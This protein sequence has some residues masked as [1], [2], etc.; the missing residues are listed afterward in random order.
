MTKCPWPQCREECVDR[1]HPMLLSANIALANFVHGR[2]AT[3][4]DIH[5]LSVALLELGK[6]MK[7]PPR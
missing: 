5:S 4:A 3:A 6:H 7:D 1:L 2:E